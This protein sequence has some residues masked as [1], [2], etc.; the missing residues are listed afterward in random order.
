M[1]ALSFAQQQHGLG[2]SQ[3]Y[4]VV[5]S[6]PKSSVDEVYHRLGFKKWSNTS[7]QPDIGRATRLLLWYTATSPV[8]CSWSFSWLR[9]FIFHLLLHFNNPYS[10]VQS[11]RHQ[12]PSCSRFPLYDQR[13]RTRTQQ[14]KLPA[15]LQSAKRRIWSRS[16][17]PL[18]WSLRSQSTNW[19][20][21]L[22]QQEPLIAW[23]L[24]WSCQRFAPCQS[25]S[26][27]YLRLVVTHSLEQL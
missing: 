15:D 21:R 7:K 16:S 24:Q 9:C 14:H 8:C 18:S 1:L 3:Q 22:T 6:S 23:S 27:E 20:W 25:A 19:R 13:S 5:T 26:W 10:F 2:L 4:T 12:L 11:V 17:P